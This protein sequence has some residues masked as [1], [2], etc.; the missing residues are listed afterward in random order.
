MDPA[1]D[2]AFYLET[3]KKE[4]AIIRGVF[5]T[6]SHADFISVCTTECMTFAEMMLELEAL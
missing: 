3:A 6:H 2:I 5:L 1:R 4:S